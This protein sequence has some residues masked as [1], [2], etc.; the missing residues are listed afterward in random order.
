MS[1]AVTFGGIQQ[2]WDAG[3]C[4]LGGQLPSI[5]G[6]ERNPQ[7]PFCLYLRG[8]GEKTLTLSWWFPPDFFF[9]L[10]LC[11]LVFIFLVISFP[12]SK[13]F[14]AN[15]SFIL[16]VSRLLLSFLMFSFLPIL[17]LFLFFPLQLIYPSKIFQVIQESQ[18]GYILFFKWMITM[19][20]KQTVKTACF[21]IPYMVQHFT[22][23]SWITNHPTNPQSFKPKQLV[24][25]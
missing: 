8:L 13:C 14:P 11:S 23:C 2:S 17:T 22:C 15:S 7:H 25:H 21:H 16:D 18:C 19:N 20:T 24:I 9:I 6:L 5:M 10:L 12:Q 1:R 3:H 4:C